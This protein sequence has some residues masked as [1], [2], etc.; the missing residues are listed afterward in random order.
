MD[1]P[2]L[3]L[4]HVRLPGHLVPLHF[5]RLNAGP[6]LAGFPGSDPLCVADGHLLAAHS[7]QTLLRGNHQRGLL[8]A[9]VGPTRLSIDA[10]RCR[11]ALTRPHTVW[12]G[13]VRGALVAMD[14]LLFDAAASLGQPSAAEAIS[15]RCGFHGVHAYIWGDAHQPPPVPQRRW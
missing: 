10:K 15:D 13:A 4:I 9:P 6:A 2:Q 5:L 11:R 3:Q 12:N 8:Q 1:D 7:S 14:D